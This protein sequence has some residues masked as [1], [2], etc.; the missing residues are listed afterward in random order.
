MNGFV[1]LLH[2]YVS[3]LIFFSRSCCSLEEE[4]VEVFSAVVPRW[5]A[6]G[7]GRSILYSPW[8]TVSSQLD[9]KVQ[10]HD[11]RGPTTSCAARVSQRFAAWRRPAKV[12]IVH[13]SQ[14]A[15]AV[16]Q[17]VSG[18]HSHTQKDCF[19]YL[20]IKPVIG[21]IVYGPVFLI[22]RKIRCT[23]T[24]Q[25][26][27]T[28]AYW[29]FNLARSHVETKSVLKEKFVHTKIKYEGKKW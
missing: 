1:E 28:L 5:R 15:E 26:N 17:F 19:Q 21:D 29:Y 6:S 8:S 10:G 23:Q 13:F 27:V 9:L 4:W 11:C 3:L 7:G 2:D 16:E 25:Y 22:L 20:L 18:T 12:T 24:L 14:N